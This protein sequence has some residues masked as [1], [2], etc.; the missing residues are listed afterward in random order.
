[1]LFYDLS[2]TWCSGN[3]HGIPWGEGCQ[4]FAKPLQWVHLKGQY[5]DAGASQRG[6]NESLPAAGHPC[7]PRGAPAEHS[8]EDGPRDVGGTEERKKTSNHFP[9]SSISPILN[10]IS[11]F[12]QDGFQLVLSSRCP[13]QRPGARREVFPQLAKLLHLKGVKG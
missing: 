5:F 8:A 7:S 11:V 13:G 9:S 6:E 3:G 4:A 1:M 12:P 2:G 10:C